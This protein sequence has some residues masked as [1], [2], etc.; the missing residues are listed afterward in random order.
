MGFSIFVYDAQSGRL[1]IAAF[2]FRNT[3]PEMLQILSITHKRL[4]WERFLWSKAHGVKEMDFGGVCDFDGADGISKF[5]LEVAKEMLY[6]VR[7]Y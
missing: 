7:Q 4:D 6:Y 3:K 5:K 2:D 1:W